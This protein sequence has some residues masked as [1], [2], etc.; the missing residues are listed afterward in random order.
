VSERRV[1]ARSGAVSRREF[2]AAGA[3]SLA[4]VAC[5]PR[6][7]NS[8]VAA[9][10]PPPNLLLIV[11]DDQ[12]VDDVGC[13]GGA[14][15]ATPNVD[16]IAKE[17]VRFT[18]AFTPT[19]ICQPSRAALHTGLY[20][21]SSGA[22]GFTPIR[23]D[24]ATLPGLLKDAGYRT[25]LLGKTHLD[26]IERF[27]FD[28][29]Q[30]SHALSSGR[31]VDAFVR[32][33]KS[34]MKECLAARQP[35]FL[36]VNFDDPHFPWP[37]TPAEAQA[38]LPRWLRR[39]SGIDPRHRALGDVAGNT[40]PAKARLPGLLPDLPEV[41]AELARYADAI[42]RLDRGVGLLLDLLDELGAAASTVVIFLSDNGM[43]FPF[44]KTTLWEGGI[45]LPLLVRWP[46]VTKPGSA[47][48]GMVSFV[49]LMPTLLEIAGAPPPGSGPKLQGRS[50]RAGLTG[51]EVALRDTVFLTH[52]RHRQDVPM[53]SRG[54]RTLRFK[55]LRNLWPPGVDFLT[56]GMRHDSWE[57]CERA[58]KN[59]PTLAER[60][61]RFLRRPPAELYDLVSDPL[62]RR[63]LA[64]SREHAE[65]ER[66]M[67]ERLRAQMA[68]IAD[69]LL[70]RM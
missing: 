32:W 56:I 46:G 21:T 38:E 59:D 16:R 3:A 6:L 42:L 29:L 63:N 45:R 53:P 35:F 66:D 28:L 65:I 26:P 22:E 1:R 34:F 52:S 36:A 11:S 49:D 48:E 51:G 40:D 23:P 25:A 44:H 8:Q 68:A 69:P 37:L 15:I 64:G 12:S 50:F 67:H 33:A 18:R 20:G 55:Y 62:E 60:V 10:E 14:S 13:Y 7:A 30:P 47:C 5:Q 57:A 9:K 70:H 54:I 19:A 2:L 31:D 58:A 43:D 61:E 4:G 24:V 27:R 39:A 17:G 41:R